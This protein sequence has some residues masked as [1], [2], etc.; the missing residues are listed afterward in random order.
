MSSLINY[1]YLLIDLKYIFSIL[2]IQSDV[3]RKPQGQIEL[4]AS[5]HIERGDGKQTIQVPAFLFFGSFFGT[6]YPELPKHPNLC[7]TGSP[8]VDL[9]LISALHFKPK[10][11]FSYR[12]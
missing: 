10:K 1:C 12:K 8:H 9:E 11:Y 5:S 4:N 3:I 6:L 2:S 7:W